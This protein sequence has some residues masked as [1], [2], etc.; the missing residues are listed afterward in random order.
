MIAVVNSGIGVWVDL[1]RWA[2]KFEA[3]WLRAVQ[4]IILAS[5]QR[6]QGVRSGDPCKALEII[7]CLGAEVCHSHSS[8]FKP[9][10]FIVRVY[11]FPKS[12]T[13]GRVPCNALWCLGGR[14]G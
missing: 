9:E 10:T 2:F 6:L 5:E 8:R 13:L 11:V 12:K 3:L 7:I 14:P 1:T 4:G